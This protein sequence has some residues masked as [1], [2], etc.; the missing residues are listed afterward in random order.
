MDDG[1]KLPKSNIQKLLDEHDASIICDEDD[2]DYWLGADS[3][4]DKLDGYFY[5]TFPHAEDEN[6]AQLEEFEQMNRCARGQHERIDVGFRHSKWVCKH[7]DK[8][9][10]EGKDF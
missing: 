5:H 9:L 8:E 10:I 1:Y 2:L 7:C 4:I 3:E 6:A